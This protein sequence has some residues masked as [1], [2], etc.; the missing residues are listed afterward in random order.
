VQDKTIRRTWVGEKVLHHP[1]GRSESPDGLLEPFGG[2]EPI[3]ETRPA[4]PTP[5][6][7]VIFRDGRVASFSYSYLR[8][9]DFEPGDSVRLRFT[10]ATVVAIE[11][12][13]LRR[14]RNQIRL[15][16]ADEIQEGS[17]SE[18]ELR[19]E[20]ELHIARISIAS[21]GDL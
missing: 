8:Q 2:A 18:G 15:H 12:R 20:D 14:I 6:L 9:V 1:A 17:E 10:D 4:I 7:D 13:N 16:R 21:E 11:G 3:K 19:K 5:M